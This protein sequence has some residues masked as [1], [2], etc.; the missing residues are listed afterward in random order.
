MKEMKEMRVNGAKKAYEAPS[1]N[2][3]ELAPFSHL[4]Q[5]SQIGGGGSGGFDVKER[6]WFFDQNSLLY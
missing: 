1:S 2:V 4:M 6:T 3:V 5:I